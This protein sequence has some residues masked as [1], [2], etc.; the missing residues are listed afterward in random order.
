MSRDHECPRGSIERVHVKKEHLNR[1]IAAGV[2]LA[3]VIGQVPTA[4]IADAVDGQV[5]AA[6]QRVEAAQSSSDSSDEEIPASDG[7]KTTGVDEGQK[8]ALA[9]TVGEDAASADDESQSQ[10]DPVSEDFAV[11]SDQDASS[12][13]DAQAT[14]SLRYHAKLT[15]K[16]L[17]DYL[18]NTFGKHI[19]SYKIVFNGNE[20]VVGTD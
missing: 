2:T 4:A 7:E 16:E 18:Y 17:R 13:I 10:S 14:E 1:T 5:P 6:E 20:T 11:A 8:D 19:S 3:M 15:K 12:L 9:P